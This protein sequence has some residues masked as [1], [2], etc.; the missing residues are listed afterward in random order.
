MSI[1]LSTF[2]R[3]RV[4][5]GLEVPN[6]TPSEVLRRTFLSASSITLRHEGLPLSGGKVLW[7][8]TTARRFLGPQHATDPQRQVVGLDVDLVEQIA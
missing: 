6:L 5:R 4:L 1:V 2:R 8:L 7:R 3:T